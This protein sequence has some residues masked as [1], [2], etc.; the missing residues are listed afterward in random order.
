MFDTEMDEAAREV[1]RTDRAPLF[2]DDRRALADHERQV[3]AFL[4]GKP[5]DDRQ[6]F[7]TAR[8]LRTDREREVPAFGPAV[9]FGEVDFSEQAAAVASGAMNTYTAADRADAAYYLENTEG[10]R[11][12]KLYNALGVLLVDRPPMTAAEIKAAL[13]MS[14]RDWRKLKTDLRQQR[15]GFQGQVRYSL[16]D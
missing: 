1:E 14:E 13:G 15:A 11:L 2:E 8:Q 9:A 12:G 6:P 16:P 4:A 10:R 5:V 3:A 7:K